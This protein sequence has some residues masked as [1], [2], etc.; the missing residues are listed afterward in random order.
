[1]GKR[2]G[3]DRGFD[4]KGTLR[5]LQFKTY[6]LLWGEGSVRTA[7]GSSWLKGPPGL[8]HHCDMLENWSHEL[9]INLFYKFPAQLGAAPAI[10][11]VGFE[12][13]QLPCSFLR[14]EHRATPYGL[15]QPTRNLHTQ[16]RSKGGTKRKQTAAAT[17][18]KKINCSSVYL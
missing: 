6:I 3:Y 11:A 5:Q 7:E 2:G 15:Q 1:M 14:I 13:G 4:E 18:K 17:T 10:W 16:S 12:R 9:Q 8:M